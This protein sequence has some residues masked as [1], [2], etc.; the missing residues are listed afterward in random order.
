MRIPVLTYHAMAMSGNGPRTND[1]H[2]LAADLEAIAAEGF[3]VRALHELVDGWL[4]KSSWFR[5]RAPLEGRRIRI[6]EHAGRS[7]CP[8]AWRT[9]VL[10]A[11]PEASP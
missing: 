9:Q 11:A 7:R 5:K 3:E 1:H 6:P 8:V 10:W 4:G 2:A